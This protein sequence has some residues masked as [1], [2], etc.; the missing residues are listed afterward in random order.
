MD[1]I[2]VFKTVH[3]VFCVVDIGTDAQ[4]KLIIGGET[5]M[6]GEFVDNTNLIARFW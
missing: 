2:L 4:K 5:C 1:C 6:W 3:D